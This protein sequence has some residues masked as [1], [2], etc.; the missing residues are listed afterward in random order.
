MNRCTCSCSRS[1][2]VARF[3]QQNPHICYS[4]ICQSRFEGS[5]SKFVFRRVNCAF[6]GV[7]SLII[8]AC[9]VLNIE[10][11]GS[12]PPRATVKS[13][14][15]TW[16]HCAALTPFPADSIQINRASSAFW[17]ALLFIHSVASAAL[18]SKMPCSEVTDAVFSAEEMQERCCERTRKLKVLKFAKLTEN[19]T[20]P[21]RGS[22]RAAGFDLYRWLARS[23]WQTNAVSLCSA[24][25]CCSARLDSCRIPVCSVSRSLV[26]F[27]SVFLTCKTSS[28]AVYSVHL[29]NCSACSCMLLCTW[30]DSC[31]IP[32]FYAPRPADNACNSSIYCC[33]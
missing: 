10:F 13:I 14:P 19:A 33:F 16:Q 17:R 7:V 18:A 31:T 29:M 11:L 9:Q 4:K 28:L 2:R 3:S 6:F 22:N 26:F 32:R 1:S 24:H 8:F 23:R 5:L 12:L 21:S 25:A 30:L 15:R 20:T 27:I